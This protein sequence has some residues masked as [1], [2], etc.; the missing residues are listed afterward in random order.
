MNWPRGGLSESALKRGFFHLNCI[1]DSIHTWSHDKPKCGISEVL[2]FF[3]NFRKVVKSLDRLASKGSLFN[4]AT[5]T[6]LLN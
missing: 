4:E 6:V 2:V 1:A 3:C 5:I